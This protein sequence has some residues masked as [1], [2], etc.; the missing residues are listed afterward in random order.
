MFS[1]YKYIA[2]GDIKPP[3]EKELVLMRKNTPSGKLY[4]MSK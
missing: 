1:S 4:T 3:A 2:V